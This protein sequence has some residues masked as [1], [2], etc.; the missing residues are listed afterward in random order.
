MAADDPYKTKWGGDYA[1]DEPGEDP[2]KTDWGSQH[3]S[4]TPDKEVYKTPGNAP[5]DIHGQPVPKDEA[6]ADNTGKKKAPDREELSQ[7]EKTGAGSKYE[8]QVGGGYKPGGQRKSGRFK[9]KLTKRRLLVGG[10][11]TG[12]IIAAIISFF[13]IGPLEIIHLSHI[14]QQPFSKSD[15]DSSNRLGKLFRAARKNDIGETRVGRLGSKIFGKTIQQLSDI[16]VDI[17]RNPLTGAPTRTNFDT[18][19]LKTQF[20]ELD[21]ASDS[22]VKSFLADK[23]G[24]TT[25]QITGSGTKFAIDQ[26]DLNLKATSLLT[27]NTLGL[28]DDGTIVGAIKSRVLSSFFNLP[29]LFHPFKRA[30][31]DK[32]NSIA[33]GVQRRAAEQQD[34]QARE[35]SLTDPAIEGEGEAAA[36]D[37]V[38]ENNTYTKGII[39]ALVV[40]GGACVVYKTAG[41]IIKINRDLVVIPAAL[42]ATDVI[43]VGEQA[44]SGQD[45]SGNQVG[46][47]IDSFSDQNGNT[48]WQG[49]A[50]DA[51]SNGG[52]T[53]QSLTDL[54]PDYKSAFNGDTTAA[55]LQSGAN[56]VINVATAGIFG[57]GSA[58]STAGIIV[59]GAIVLTA[60]AIS[61]FG[62]LASAGTLTPAV[63]AELALYW[64]A[65]QV[66]NVAST[67]IALH[68]INNFVLGKTTA[69]LAKDAF[70]GPVGGDLLAYGARGSANISAIASGGISLGNKAS[71]SL[72]AQ[73]QKQSEQQ[74]QS[75]S[76]AKRLF[77]PYDYRSAISKIIDNTGTSPARTVSRIGN[78]FTNFSSMFVHSFSALMPHAQA[79]GTP[80]SW[81][82]P[83]YGLPDNIL[84]DPSLADPYTNADAVAK[85]LDGS[86]GP[87]YIS[88]AMACF[89]V[90]ISNQN[91]DNVWDALPTTDVD[92]SS[93]SYISANCNDTDEDWHR[94]IMFVF[95][96]A[97]MKAAACY[98][99]DEQSCVDLGA[100]AGT[101]GSSGSS[102]NNPGS[103]TGSL[104]TGTAQQLAQQ[105]VPYV[106]NGKIKCVGLGGNYGCSDITNTATGVSIKGGVGCT[107][108]SL[109]PALLGM[110]LKLAQMGHTF[111]L[112]A[113]C[114]DHHNDSL[115]GHAGGRAADFNT[116][117]GVFMGPDD[118]PWSQTKID[119]ASKLDQD[120]LSFIPAAEV[121]FGQVGV[122]SDGV[123]CHPDF[124]FM[125]GADTFGDVCHHQHVQ[126]ET[127]G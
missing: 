85:L 52:T 90:T 42:R 63:S 43:A 50:L 18:E 9:V 16:G 91:S 65:K 34:E 111:A 107:V 48:I 76:L 27:N 118:A 73:E 6:I 97:T 70:S 49:Q 114:S 77:D 93:D 75:M 80:Y 37:V 109:Q 98:E 53:N 79:A 89:G 45:L 33:N 58:C 101:S 15:S 46:T 71:I 7:K 60:S 59:Q 112:S 61:A 35:G 55:S 20:P 113:L 2:Y 120:I 88:R 96:T 3:S 22:E 25:D 41:D 67:G 92:P 62:D 82:F 17:E 23:L 12:F 125:S 28:L 13:A 51:L 84:N 40:T 24:V 115:N 126:V 87:G 123:R 108:D 127:N 110:L 38:G 83:Q 94:V 30:I 66:F 57:A 39:G 1:S 124:S 54:P 104:P 121:G 19:K 64:G 32:E 69:K 14:L 47:L 100:E 102:T 106:N 10:G 119:A 56:T 116:I 122:N 11:V 68:F 29:S 8:D 31:A 103:T 36:K 74:F 44:G 117:D 86:G 4:D 99:S 105:L 78:L 72:A 26:L 81:N 21:G 5:S 95:D